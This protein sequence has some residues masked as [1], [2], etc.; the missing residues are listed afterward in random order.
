[1]KQYKLFGYEINTWFH[2]R[3]S[4]N[5]TEEEKDFIWREWTIGLSFK[6]NKLVGA[7]NFNKPPE[8]KNNLILEYCFNI[9]LL[10]I[11]LTLHF[12]RKGVKTFGI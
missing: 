3:Y 8:W 5:K 9:K 1:M 6:I 11:E 2:Y 7:R 4:K 12:R 10:I